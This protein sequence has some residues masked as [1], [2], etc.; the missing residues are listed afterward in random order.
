LS[1]QP[2]I[3]RLGAVRFSSER[4]AAERIESDVELMETINWARKTAYA[5]TVRRQ[6][7]AHAVK[8]DRR[9]LPRISQAFDDIAQRTELA[10]SFEAYVH[11]APEINAAVISAQDKKIVVLTSGAIE[12]LGRDELDFVIGHELGHTE[13]RH[14]DIP[15]PVLMG[16]TGTLKPRQAMRLM[17]WQRKAE[18]SADRVGLLCCGTLEVAARTMFK[19]LS[20]LSLPELQMNPQDFARQW[21][22]LAEEMRRDAGADQWI[23]THPFGPLRMK[24]MIG[25]CQADETRPLIPGAHGG[26][27]LAEIDE[28]I[29]HLLAMMDPLA[30][31]GSTGE[32]RADP[33][34]QD[35]L[36]WGGLFVAASDGSVADSELADL[37][38]LVGA[39]IIRHVG[40]AGTRQPAEFRDLFF[41]ALAERK[42]PLTALELHRIFSGLAVIA[43]A[44]GTIHPDEL[45][46]LRELARGCGLS[47]AVVDSLLH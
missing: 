35:F 9:V 47:E 4:V 3:G 26:R 12:R 15:V 2:S 19:T 34:L 28:E 43:K 45:G 31:E 18:I 33:M 30:R 27:P 38:S 7:L 44:D 40:D 36:L 24:A 14:A 25:F 5:S 11:A 1:A 37:T 46:A 42:S 13:Y 22:E 32:S 8:V 23:M 10:Q 20:G 41:K 17:S 6:L 39:E 29:D 16:D 21:D